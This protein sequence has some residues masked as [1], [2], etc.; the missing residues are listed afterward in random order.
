VVPGRDEVYFWFVSIDSSGNMVDRGIWR[1]LNGGAWTQISET[2]I[3]NCG[4]GDGCGVKQSY[5]N[6]VIAAVPDGGTQTDLYAGT[7]NL[8]KCVLPTNQTTCKTV[9]LNLPNSWLNLTHVYGSCSSKAMVHPDQHGIDFMV[10]GGKDI[11]YFGNDGGVYRAVDGFMGL[12]VGSCNTPGTNAFDNLNGTLGSMTQ[13]VSF[14]VHATD[15]NTV[16]GGTQDN[17][18]PASTNATGSSQFVTANG[19]DGGYNIIDA[20]NNLWYTANTD[21]SVQ[22]CNTPPSCTTPSFHPVVNAGTA[23]IGGD[24]GAFYSPYILDPQNLNELLVGT[25]RVWRGSTSGSGFTA[26]SPNFDTGIA[27]TCNGNEINQVRSIA[28]GGAKNSSGFSSVV[29]ATSD[30]TGPNCTPANNCNGPLGGEV[31]VTTTAGTGAMLNVTGAINPSHYTISS[32]ALDSTDGTG[33]TAYIGI[34]GFVGST[35]AHVFKTTNSGQTWSAFGNTSSGLPDA[36]VNALLVDGA[37]GK[38]YAGTDVGLF[39]SS[40]SSAA[41]MEVGPAPGPGVTGYLPNVPVSALRMFNAGGTKKLRASTYGRGIWEYALAVAPDFTNTIA[42]S[43]QTVF[44]SQ[45]ASF[46]GTLTALNSYNSAVNLSCTGTRPATCTLN[47]TAV[48]P[49]TVGASY[50]VTAGGAVGDY[51]FIAHGVG[52]DTNATTRDAAATLHV[53]DFAVGAVSPNPISVAQGLTRTATFQ[54]TASGSFGLAVSLSC[55]GLPA[56]ATCS[57]SPSSPVNPTSANPVTVTLTVSAA[58]NTPQ[59]I[60]TVTVQGATAAPAATR[61][62]TFSLTVTAPPDFTWTSSGST[63]Q[64]VLAGQTTPAYNFTATPVSG[65]TFTGAVTL[66]CSGLPDATAVCVFSPASIA[67]GSGTTPVSLTITTKGPNTGT[68]AGSQRWE[69]H[70]PWLPMALPIMEL[71]MAGIAGRKVWRHSELAGLGVALATMG[72]MLA[73]GS[74]SS[75]GGGGGEISVS[76]TPTTTV[77][78]WPSVAG[79]PAQTQ[80]FSATVIGATDQTVTWAVVGGSANGSVDPTGMY[81]APATV[82][83]PAAVTITATAAADHRKS[84]SGRINIQTPTAVGTFNVTVTATEGSVAHSQGVTLTVQ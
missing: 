69:E 46:N 45:I 28:A 22:V 27:G 26:L 70:R 61:T 6:L 56:N 82:P 18:S 50:T 49:T 4:D 80:K 34:M 37:A 71:L 15:Q 11:M 7:I 17:G 5:Y 29:Y 23:T 12:N 41:W 62:T 19:G 8:Y 24:H 13:F 55:S 20:T 51:D 9:D 60:S 75:G 36:P 64:T 76:V 53:V 67:A 81:S 43:P 84:G 38:I 21:V 72:M 47:P 78:L 73:C 57:F 48:T 16:L 1:S 40:T 2:G 59:G 3:T 35:N 54:A 74:V 42:N 10:A 31:W 32:V 33:G 30:G 79:W 66:G 83:S 63:S 39:V 65:S 77:N 52:T 68:G 58:A 44:P 25:C 14:S